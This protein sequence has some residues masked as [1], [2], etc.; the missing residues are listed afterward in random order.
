MLKGQK[1]K[2]A[3]CPLGCDAYSGAGFVSHVQISAG[4]ALRAAYLAPVL[5]AIDWSAVKPGQVFEAGQSQAPAAEPQVVEKHTPLCE[6]ADC[7]ICRDTEAKIKGAVMRQAVADTKTAIF[8]QLERSARW[9]GKLAEADAVAVAF[10][11][12]HEAG[13]PEAPEDEAFEAGAQEFSVAVRKAIPGIA[14]WN[15]YAGGTGAA[16]GKNSYDIRGD[17]GL[18]SIS[19]FTTRYGRHAGYAVKFAD[20]KGRLGGGLW[21]DLG[22]VRSPNAGVRAA[23]QHY[24][25]HFEAEAGQGDV[26]EPDADMGARAFFNEGDTVKITKG[27]HKGKTGKIVGDPDDMGQ[28]PVVGAGGKSLGNFP[29]D[30]LARLVNP[31]EPMAPETAEYVLAML[32]KFHGDTEKLARWMRD[33]LHIGPIGE[34]RDLIAQAN[35]LGR[36]AHVGNLADRLVTVTR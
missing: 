4:H 9:A 15:M 20:E 27:F 32:D 25:E 22:T 19:P 29:D 7:Q 28:Y 12:W 36:Q 11:A 31:P 14:D 34:V 3:L 24:A 30:A 1:P 10:K 18:Y 33:Q 23:R 21:T 35:A 16:E 5:G 17:F 6:S 26:A 2:K 8:G 13:K